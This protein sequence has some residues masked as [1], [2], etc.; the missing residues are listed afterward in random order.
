M[1]QPAISTGSWGRGPAR[2]SAQHGAQ[3][4]KSACRAKVTLDKYIS[5]TI[6]QSEEMRRNLRRKSCAAGCSPRMEAPPLEETG[7]R[8]A[9]MAETPCKIRR[10]GLVND[11]NELQARCGNRFAPL[12]MAGTSGNGGNSL[13]R[14][15]PEKPS[16]VL[17]SHPRA[18]DWHNACGNC[19]K[20]HLTIPPGARNS[21]AVPTSRRTTSSWMEAASTIWAIGTDSLAAW[22]C[23]PEPGPKLMISMP[24]SA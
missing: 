4:L 20:C 24:S 13:Q 18:A 14:L 19:G 5:N 23:A 21:R 10:V 2:V 17:P 7:K 15:C 9:E 22:P 1:A 16:A 3:K 12:G 8:L 6:I 11:I